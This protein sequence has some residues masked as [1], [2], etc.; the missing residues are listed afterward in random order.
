MS[1][2]EHGVY[3][4]PLPIIPFHPSSS[5][6]IQIP[7]VHCLPSEHRMML[8]VLNGVLHHHVRVPPMSASIACAAAQCIPIEGSTH[9]IPPLKGGI[10]SRFQSASHCRFWSLVLV[11]AASVSLRGA[12]DGRNLLGDGDLAAAD[13]HDGGHEPTS[14]SR[15][16]YFR[17]PNQLELSRQES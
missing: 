10:A 11:L 13:R 7:S 12:D 9:L 8:I 14:A 17:K 6:Y 3:A 4:L 2:A 15:Q 1:I 16:F 5:I